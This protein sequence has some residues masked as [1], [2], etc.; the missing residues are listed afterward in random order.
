MI[1]IKNFLMLNLIL[2]TKKEKLIIRYVISIDQSFI[3]QAPPDP[4]LTQI[5]PDGQL[6]LE[7]S[8]ATTSCCL[9]TLRELAIKRSAPRINSFITFDLTFNLM[10]I[11]LNMFFSCGFIRLRVSR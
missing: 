9:S 8:Q 10:K 6:F 5:V 2:D 7:R 4:Y 11:L 1:N 3:M